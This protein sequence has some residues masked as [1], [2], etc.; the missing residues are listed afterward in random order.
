MDAFVVRKLS[1]ISITLCTDRYGWGVFERVDGKLKL[2]SRHEKRVLARDA[3]DQ[4]VEEERKYG[5]TD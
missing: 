1:A 3:K 5:R 2:V 4:L